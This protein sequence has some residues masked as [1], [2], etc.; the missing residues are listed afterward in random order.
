MIIKLSLKSHFK[1][2]KK[3]QR[4]KNIREKKIFVKD[5]YIFLMTLNS[6]LDKELFEVNLIFSK[7]KYLKINLL[8]SPIR[9]KKFF[10]QI[11]SEVFFVKIHIFYSNAR[12]INY[13]EVIGIFSLLD[14]KL[15]VLGTNLLTKHKI[16]VCFLHVFAVI[17]D[18]GDESENVTVLVPNVNSFKKITNNST[19]NSIIQI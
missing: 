17:D 18:Y 8:K 14:S 5:I 10:N 12:Y 2:F 13:K 15:N 6:F 9:H 3:L 1:F 19:N 4:N 16:V 11:F 7:K